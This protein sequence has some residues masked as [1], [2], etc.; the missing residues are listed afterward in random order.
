[1]KT[2]LD[3]ANE[4]LLHIIGDVQPEDILD[5]SLSCKFLHALARDTLAQHMLRVCISGFRAAAVVLPK[6]A[7]QAIT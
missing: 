2:F 5:V 3:L 6:H 1:M 7:L 4:T